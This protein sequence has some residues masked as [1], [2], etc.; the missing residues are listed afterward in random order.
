MHRDD[1]GFVEND[2]ARFFIFPIAPEIETFGLRIRKNIV[3]SIV[4]VW[5]FDRA[6][7]MDGNQVRREQHIFLRHLRDVT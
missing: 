7:G 5:K 4:E 2:G 1:A 6:S 3:V